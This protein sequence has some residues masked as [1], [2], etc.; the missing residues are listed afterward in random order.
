MKITV[1][2][3]KLAPLIVCKITFN[4]LKLVYK[5]IQIHKTNNAFNA[6]SKDVSNVMLVK[7]AQNV[8][9]IYNLVKKII[10]VFYNKTFVNQMRSLLSPLLH[11]VN[12][13]KYAPLSLIKILKLINASKYNSAHILK[14][15]LIISI[16]EYC[17]LTHFQVINTLLEVINAN[18]HQPTKIQRQSIQIF[19]K[20]QL[21]LKNYTCNMGQ[22]LI[23][24][25]LQQ[26]IMVGA[27][28]IRAQLL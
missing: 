18:L 7:I 6:Q 9:L 5:V 11:K 21:I 15:V 3:V 19:Y 27:Q 12:A 20:I 25:V 17:K 16:K 13:K 1:Q 10:S 14:V 26:G 28:Q 22:K 8:M 23:K 2:N 24:K 4:V